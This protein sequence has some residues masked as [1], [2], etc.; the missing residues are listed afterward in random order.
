[1]KHNKNLYEKEV[2]GEDK[3]IVKNNE[4]EEKNDFNINL[5]KKVETIIDKIKL[6]KN[7]NKLGETIK[8]I[9]FGTS[10][11]SSTENISLDE[12]CKKGKMVKYIIGQDNNNS[13]NQ[14]LQ[15]K[16]RR[17]RRLLV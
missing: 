7:K 10:D 5:G 9:E 6:E 11:E 15:K 14:T 2:C 13:E 4:N 1:M 8:I 17:P 3:N 16:R 12:M